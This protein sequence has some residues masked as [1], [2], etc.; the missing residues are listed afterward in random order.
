MALSLAGA[1]LC[2]DNLQCLMHHPDPFAAVGFQINFF[3]NRRAQH[4]LADRPL[5]QTGYNVDIKG[6]KYTR[7]LTILKDSIQFIPLYRCITQV[8]GERLGPY[9]QQDEHG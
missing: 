8:A 1:T 5:D 2:G 4:I 9:E 7:L 3:C 6:S